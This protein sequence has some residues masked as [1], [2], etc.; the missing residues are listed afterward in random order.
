M[1]RTEHKTSLLSVPGGTLLS[2]MIST[3]G[4]LGNIIHAN[5]DT[6]GQLLRGQGNSH[7]NSKSSDNQR[8]SSYRAL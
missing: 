2:G 4:K 7:H 1:K 5:D 3:V 6:P 8:L